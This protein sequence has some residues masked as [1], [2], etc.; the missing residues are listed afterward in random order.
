MFEIG[1][2]IGLQ[3]DKIRYVGAEQL[4]KYCGLYLNIVS[5][6]LE[7]ESDACVGMIR[8]IKRWESEKAIESM[9]DFIYEIEHIQMKISNPD[10]DWVAIQD[11]WDIATE[12]LSEIVERA[13]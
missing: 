6:I 3:Q 5:D 11:S 12:C 13:I 1:Y 10:I 4:D 9:G 7:E 2:D 8:P